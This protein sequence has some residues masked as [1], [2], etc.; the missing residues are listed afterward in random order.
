MVIPLL[1]VI[2]ISHVSWTD[3][4]WDIFAENIDTKT[5]ISDNRM[6]GGPVA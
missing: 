2:E 5:T 1:L 3:F 4:K 6:V